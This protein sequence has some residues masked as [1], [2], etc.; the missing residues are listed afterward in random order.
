[1][2][3]PKRWHA[4]E[5]S[6]SRDRLPAYPDDPARGRA[7]SLSTETPTS[8]HP[9]AAVA[10]PPP[11]ATRRRRSPLSLLGILV[12]IVALGGVVYWALQQDAPTLPDSPGEILALV[13]AI[14]LYGLAPV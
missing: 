1:M 12:S 3:R 10:P 9:L 14:A 5:N 7:R 11:A 2:A 13:G 4:P 8:E 6:G